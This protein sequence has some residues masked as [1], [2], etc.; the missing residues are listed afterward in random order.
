[1]EAI[2]VPQAKHRRAFPDV[3]R[4]VELP[5]G[6]CRLLRVAPIR[7]LGVGVIARST[8]VRE[9]DGRS[10]WS[11]A[12]VLSAGRSCAR[13]KRRRYVPHHPAQVH[14]RG[15]L[16]LRKRIRT[17]EPSPALPAR[18]RHPPAAPEHFHEGTARSTGW[19]SDRR[20]GRELRTPPQHAA[21]GH[22]R[23]RAFRTSD[24]N[25]VRGR[26]A[27]YRSPE[28]RPNDPGKNVRSPPPGLPC[29]KVGRFPVSYTAARRRSSSAGQRGSRVSPAPA[30]QEGRPRRGARPRCSAPVFRRRTPAQ[31]PAPR[32]PRA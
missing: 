10:D 19:P 28:R 24:A 5:R 2:E 14:Q 23:T 17:D 3:R 9:T 26:S 15:P 4:A 1:M 20:Q 7:A 30:A 12:R 32:R 21:N 6:F 11:S 18:P 27:T 16:V 29:E 31:S 22:D 8:E 13:T 25:P